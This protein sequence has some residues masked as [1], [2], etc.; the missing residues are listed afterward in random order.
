MTHL[1]LSQMVERGKGAIVNLSAGGSSK[2]TPQMTVYAATKV[3]QTT[4]LANH[5]SHCNMSANH[6]GHCKVLA[7]HGSHCNILT[8]L[9]LL[10]II[11][12]FILAFSQ[13]ITITCTSNPKY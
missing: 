9:V 8:N 5:V 6:G 3:V 10:D 11:V 7:N 4:F 12:E 2:P 13:L 1:I